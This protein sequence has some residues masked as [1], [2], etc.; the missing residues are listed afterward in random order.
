M[1]VV[2]QQVVAEEQEQLDKQLQLVMTQVTVET[3]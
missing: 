1:L 2:T 3:V